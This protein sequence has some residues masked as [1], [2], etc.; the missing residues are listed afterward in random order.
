MDVDQYT[1]SLRRAAES[2]LQGRAT[3]ALARCAQFEAPSESSHSLYDGRN[4]AAQSTAHQSLGS[5][6]DDGCVIRESTI[7]QLRA[8]THR[9]AQPADAK[10][11][12][13]QVRGRGTQSDARA[14][15][16]ARNDLVP[17]VSAGTVSR[18]HPH[19]CRA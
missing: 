14:A 19:L 13:S 10:T 8:M 18:W 12:A 3:E 6:P 9:A 16:P 1:K 5:P 7:K 15:L 17:I 2:Q 4:A 11:C